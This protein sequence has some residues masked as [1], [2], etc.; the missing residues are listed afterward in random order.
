VL[1]SFVIDSVSEIAPAKVNL[2]LSVGPPGV[3]RMHPIC[4]WMITVDLHDEL[5]LTRLEEGSLSRYAILWH[6]DAPRRSEID[7]SITRDLAVRAHLS[8]EQL[9]GR[10]LPVQMRLEKRIPVGGGL[11][12]GSSD[13]AAMLRGLNRLF[14]LRLPVRD[15]AAIGATLG[16]DIP[17]LIEGRSAI[18]EGLGER[19]EPLKPLP[20]VHLALAFPA[21]TCP[22]GPVY[23]AFDRLGHAVLRCEAVRS[24]ASRCGAG[25]TLDCAGPFNDLL[26]AAIEVAP[27]LEDD[28]EEL[29]ELAQRPAHLSG[30]G[31]TIF[32]VCDDPMHAAALAAAIE[33]RLDLP[34]V[35]AG[36]IGV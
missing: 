15:L 25:G 33:Q 36:S 4:S 30:S 22:T 24:L 12:G 13:A 1:P 7:W 27:T 29:A 8:L 19:L 18:V 14:D 20:G 34:A 23:A 28:L 3:D 17:F 26:P 6:K 9:V 16:S 31:S 10:A 32:V 2:A 35:A 21:A 11:G 5:H